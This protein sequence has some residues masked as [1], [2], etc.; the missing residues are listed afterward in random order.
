M[1]L[2]FARRER[3]DVSYG[4]TAIAR[5]HCEGRKNQKGF[6]TSPGGGTLAAGRNTPHQDDT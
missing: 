4:P 3:E 5:L 6:W 2:A 1:P